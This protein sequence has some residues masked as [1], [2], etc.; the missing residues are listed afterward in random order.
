MSTGGANSVYLSRPSPDLTE[1]ACSGTIECALAGMADQLLIFG[2]L[3]VMLFVAIA[4]LAFLPRARELCNRERQRTRDELDAFDRF[5]DHVRDIPATSAASAVEPAGVA[6]IVQGHA[7]A[8]QASAPKVRD[9]YEETVMGVEHFDEDYDETIGEHMSAEFSEEIAHAALAGG[10]FGPH[11]KR[12]VVEAAKE[13]RERRE[14]FLSL[15]EEEASSLEGHEGRLLEIGERVH[16]ASEPL[17]ADQTFDELTEHRDRLTDCR[18]SL[19]R[20]VDR[21]QADRF[22]GHGTIL[23]FKKELDLQEYLYRPMEVTYPVLAEAARLLSQAE[24]ATRRI[25][26]ELIYRA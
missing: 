5:V 21:R 17:C 4:S 6:P 23:A 24:V 25:E 22:E 9:A 12:G 1:A 11:V 3:G 7:G 14:Q 18:E 13:A 8:G 16:E 26:D 19:E 2:W 20:V 10:E 15:L